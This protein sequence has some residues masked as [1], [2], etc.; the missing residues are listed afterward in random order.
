MVYLT[1]GSYTWSGWVTCHGLLG[2]RA[3]GRWSLES[4]LVD[5]TFTHATLPAILLDGK[6]Q[7]PPYSPP[8][9]IQGPG[10]PLVLLG[11]THFLATVSAS[12]PAGAASCNVHGSE[13]IEVMEQMAVTF[14]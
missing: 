1:S 6:F 14:S 3:E 13:W 12:L 8:A 11:V 7:A 4:F 9:P 2:S 10:Q 5:E